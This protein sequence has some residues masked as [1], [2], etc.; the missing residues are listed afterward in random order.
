[1]ATPNGLALGLELLAHAELAPATKAHAL[2]RMA[3][4]SVANI[5]QIRR[6]PTGAGAEVEALCRAMHQE[7]EMMRRTAID[8]DRQVEALPPPDAVPVTAENTPGGA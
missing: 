6:T 2:R 4:Q 8:Y 3:D 5:E 1:M 7:V